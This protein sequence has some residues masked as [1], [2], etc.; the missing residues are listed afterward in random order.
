MDALHLLALVGIGLAAGVVNTLAGAGSLLTL[1]ALL[2][3]GLPATEANA[4][5]RV[6]VLLQSIVAGARFRQAGV[7]D[8]ALAWRLIVPTCLGAVL[9]AWLSVD[10][11]EVVFRRIIG[12]MMLAMVAVIFARPQRWIVGRKGEP[13][14]HLRWSAPLVF[15]AIG[16]YGGF[17]Q[18]GVG[19]FL[20]AGIV[21]AQGRDLVRSNAL[22]VVLVAGFTLPSLL[23]FL[24][25]DLVRWVP[26]LALAL[27]GMAGGWLGAR[28]GLHQGA[29]FLRWALIAVV[30]VSAT[31]LLGLW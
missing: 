13:P 5:N 29:A 11:D 3:V 22:K 12:G 19:V 10:L 30:L 2:W 24:A 27:G 8:G 31:K 23:L 17:L 15:F 4:T 21:W 26:G 1:P 18:A 6:G 20:L 28:I 16:A 7:L 25:Y 14:A 9:G